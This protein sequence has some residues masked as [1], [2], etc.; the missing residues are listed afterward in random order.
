MPITLKPNIVKYKD[1]DSGQYKVMTAITDDI[2]DAMGDWLDE[3]VAYTNGFITEE[4][5]IVSAHVSEWGADSTS[6]SENLKFR[7]FHL[8]NN[9]T[10]VAMDKLTVNN[11]LL[12]TYSSVDSSIYESVNIGTGDLSNLDTAAK[13]DLVSAINEVLMIASNIHFPSPINSVEDYGATG[14]GTTDDQPAIQRALD[15]ARDNGGGV[16]HF[17]AGEYLINNPLLYYSNQTLWF[18]PGAI[19]RQGN[20]QMDSLLRSYCETSYTGYNGV[21]DVLIYGGTFDGAQFTNNVTLAATVHAKNIIFEKCSFIN[22]HG[23]W[24]NLEINSSYN[25]KVKDCIFDGTG[26][27]DLTGEMIQIDSAIVSGMYPWSGVTYDGTY[28][29]C[30]DIDGCLFHNNTA[31][32][33]IGN[34]WFNST[35]SIFAYNEFI[36]IH[37]CIFDGLNSTASGYSVIKFESHTLDVDIHDN[38]FINCAICINYNLNETTVNDWKTAHYVHDNRFYGATTA[39]GSNCHCIAHA[40]LINGT[41][42]A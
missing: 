38:T 31:S 6:E 1:P 29:K 42:T 23:S 14:N 18:E 19:I 8:N 10:L 35:D 25:V 13:T 16:I 36:R 9:S 32:P 33:A 40:N 22:A 27:S 39:I 11:G 24:H 12:K 28:T 2:H 5:G 26:K 34:H 4:E 41:Y 7:G 21:H 30:V 17:P 3:H 20:S 15:D 37:N